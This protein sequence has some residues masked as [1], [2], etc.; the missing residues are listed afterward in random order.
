MYVTRPG[1]SWSRDPSPR[2][3]L[4]GTPTNPRQTGSDHEHFAA[5]D[6]VVE[7]AKP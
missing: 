6:L 3:G 2:T 1:T 7:A 4:G 5:V